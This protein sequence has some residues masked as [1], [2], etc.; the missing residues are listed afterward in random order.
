MRDFIVTIRTASG[1]NLTIKA[2]ARSTSE[3]IVAVTKAINEL[4]VRAIGR[5]A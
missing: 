3:A 5:L 1:R 2:L 4:P